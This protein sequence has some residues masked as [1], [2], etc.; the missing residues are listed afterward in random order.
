MLDWFVDQ[1]PAVSAVL[2]MNGKQDDRSM[3]VTEHETFSYKTINWIV[4]TVWKGNGIR[5]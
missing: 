2:Y 4:E 5:V 1:E 3:I